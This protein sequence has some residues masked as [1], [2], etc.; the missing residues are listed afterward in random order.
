MRVKIKGGTARESDPALCLSCR[1]A[2]IVRGARQRDEIVRCGRAETAITFKVTS[3]TEY[4]D[5]N[6]PLL[7]HMED[8]AWVLRTNARRNQIGF[9]R[10]KDLKARD[11]SYFDED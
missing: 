2:V 5:R 10:G 6:H 9:V 1:F 3:C 8:I 7:Y 4:I 11:R